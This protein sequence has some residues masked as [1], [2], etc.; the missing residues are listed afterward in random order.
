MLIP[1]TPRIIS[2]VHDRQV[3]QLTYVTLRLERVGPTPLGHDNYT[4]VVLFDFSYKTNHYMRRTIWFDGKHYG[5]VVMGAIASQI[6]SLTIV[7]PTVY[8]DADQRKH[9]S[10]ASLAFV[11]EFTD[12]I[13]ISH[14]IG[15]ICNHLNICIG[16]IMQ[17]HVTKFLIG[18][19]SRSQWISRK[20]LHNIYAYWY[21]LFSNNTN[22]NLP[23]CKLSWK[24]K[25]HAK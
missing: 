21:Q 25:G 13:I 20:P 19:G 23:S 11:W 3:E 17:A 8:S 10:S 5:D 12:V 18:C 24:M 2:N 22:K 14:K 1:H 9:Q 16:T 7:Y 6:T 15:D 4:M